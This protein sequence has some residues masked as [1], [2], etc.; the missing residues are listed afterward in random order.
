MN[1]I[2]QKL[3]EDF[4]EYFILV[5]LLVISLITI[6]Y[7]QTPAVKKVRA[8]AFGTFAAVSSVVSDVINIT[9]LRTENNELRKTNAELMLQVNKLREYG[10]VNEELRRLLSIKDTADFPLYPATVVSRSLN[11]SQSV[12]TINKGLGTGIRAGMPVI[13]D[14]GLV[15]IVN[16]VSEDY[17]IVRTLKNLDLKLTV[18]DERSRVDGIMKWNGNNLVIVNVPKTFDVEP[19]DRIMVSEIS[20]L[21][22][23]PLPVGVVQELSKVETGIFNEVKIQPFVDFSSV[24]N[25]FVIGLVRSLEKNNIELNFYNSE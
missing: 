4:K 3:W 18:K 23:L 10:I 11:R 13:N 22:S 5:F 8:V 17:A 7:N 9:R 6:S 16:S 14:H 12:L 19:G 2:F 15:G 1:R 24:E 21:I 20:S 25:I